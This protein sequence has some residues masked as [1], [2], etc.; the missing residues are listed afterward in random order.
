MLVLKSL[1]GTLAVPLPIALLLALIGLG[2]QLRRR[3]RSAA[4]LYTA[5]GCVVYLA[6]IGPVSNL[7]LAPLELSYPPLREDASLRGIPA[8]VVLGST[9]APR[10]GIPVTAA[11]DED[12]VVRLVEG[13][14]LQ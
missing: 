1:I 8:I 12:G 5:A 6:S 10:N 3:F 14:R 13:V 9:Y 4:A 11:L 7:L 2:S